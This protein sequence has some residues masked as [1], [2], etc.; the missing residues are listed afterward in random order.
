MAGRKP[1]RKPKRSPKRGG[2]KDPVAL[3]I[4]KD[5]RDMSQA[6]QFVTEYE[7]MT[8]R[9]VPNENLIVKKTPGGY[10]VSIILKRYKQFAKAG[11]RDLK[12]IRGDMRPKR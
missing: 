10:R 3:E 9:R 11:P 5:V 6:T 4:V 2:A 1:D 12:R 8:G 7:E